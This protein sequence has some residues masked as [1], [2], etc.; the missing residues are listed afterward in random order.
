[1][2]MGAMPCEENEESINIVSYRKDAQ[3]LINNSIAS[4][5]KHSYTLIS[6]IIYT[7]EKHCQ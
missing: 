7:C 4:M 3:L 5:G 2:M 1:M 6:C